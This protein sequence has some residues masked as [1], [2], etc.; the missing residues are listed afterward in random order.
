[1]SANLTH[2]AFITGVVAAPV[3]H[4]DISGQL[5]AHRG[6]GIDLSFVRVADNSLR[7]A[8]APKYSDERVDAWNAWPSTDPSNPPVPHSRTT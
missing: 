8:L 5:R 7:G 4:K 2:P 6:G 3:S 1:M